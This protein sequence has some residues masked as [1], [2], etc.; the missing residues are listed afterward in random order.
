MKAINTYITEKLRISKSKSSKNRKYTLFPETKP[1]LIQMIKDEMYKNGNKCNYE[2]NLNH[3]DTSKITDMSW[4]FGKPDYSAYGLEKFNGDISEW[5]VSNVKRMYG[6]FLGNKSFNNDISQWDVSNVE[7]MSYMFSGSGFNG[8]IYNWNVSNVKNMEG[9]FEYSDFNQDISGWD[10][11]SV[12]D[13]SYIF[14]HC[15]IKD[16]YKPFKNGKKL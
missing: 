14:D 13:M 10:V 2:C 15:N 12:Q 6:M 7:S 11:S 3:I 5:D 1:E 8:D 16:K 9:M 4:I